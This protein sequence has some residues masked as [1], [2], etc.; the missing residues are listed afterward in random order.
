M[1]MNNK[2]DS[3]ILNKWWADGVPISGVGGA[4]GVAVA[5]PARMTMIGGAT[6]TFTG[7][8][9]HF[10]LTGASTIDGHYLGDVVISAIDAGDTNIGNV[11]IVTLPAL[12][13]TTPVLTNVSIVLPDTEYMQGLPASCRA[14]QFQCRTPTD[15]RYAWAT[16]KVATPT[17]PYFTLKA[18]AAYWQEGL[19]LTAATLHIA[20][21]A[22]TLKV[23]VETWV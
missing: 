22:S 23:E 7:G 9:Q 4:S 15:V 18:G 17:D 2:S 20:A 11:D 3:F 8:A 13:K 16:G 21:A 10:V 14:I 12:E 6:P 19:K 5:L 1:A